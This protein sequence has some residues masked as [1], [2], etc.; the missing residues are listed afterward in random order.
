MTVS[1]QAIIGRL[2]QVKQSQASFIK[3]SNRRQ[4]VSSRVVV[5]KLCQ[6][7]QLRAEQF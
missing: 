5:G 1:S 7:E 2:C 3:Q 6:A 4:A